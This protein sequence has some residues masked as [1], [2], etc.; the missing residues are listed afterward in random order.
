MPYETIPQSFKD[1]ARA[2]NADHVIEE[3]DIPAELQRWEILNKGLF[4]NPAPDFKTVCDYLLEE[5]FTFVAKFNF[6]K[7]IV[8]YYFLAYGEVATKEYLQKVIDRQLISEARLHTYGILSALP[9]DGTEFKNEAAAIWKI[10]FTAAEISISQLKEKADLS[11]QIEHYLMMGLSHEKGWH[12]LPKDIFKSLAYFKIAADKGS[13]CAQFAVGLCYK[14][15]G[16]CVP[17]AEKAIYQ[18]EAKRHIFQA[19][20]RGFARAQFEVACWYENGMYDV[21]QNAELAVKYY[22]LAAQQYEPS[23]ICNLGIC[24]AQG[25][26]VAKDAKQA[27]D[28]YKL[29]AQQHH[30][31]ALNN[32][33]LACANGIAGVIP[34]NEIQAA[35]FFRL[36]AEENHPEGLYHFGIFCESGRGG[37][38]QN[39]AQAINAYKKAVERGSAAAAN[40]LREIAAQMEEAERASQSAASSALSA[41]SVFS[42][43]TAGAVMM[44]PVSPS[45]L[46]GTTN[47]SQPRGTP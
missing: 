14:F 43:P 27:V 13:V 28:C 36:A 6:F 29:A 33:G 44:P 18:S 16:E 37:V 11:S 32:L 39:F 15:M 17:L 40:R 20:Q 25:K 41:G 31:A 38:A 30:G 5:Q 7:R 24:F 23:A 22:R 4:A 9:P 12:G 3:K 1:A 10:N 42:T 26:G 2:I 45:L 35:T 47:P 46:V 8:Q 34:A 19:A 21:G